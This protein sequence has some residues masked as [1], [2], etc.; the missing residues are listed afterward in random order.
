MR[1]NTDS[2]CPNSALAIYSGGKAV[3]KDTTESTSSI[4][5]SLLAAGGLGVSKK[6]YLG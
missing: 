1:G 6:T 3:V 5:G 2:P 4:T